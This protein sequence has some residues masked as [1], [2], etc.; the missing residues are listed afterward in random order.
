MVSRAV[1]IENGPPGMVI[2]SGYVSDFEEFDQPGEVRAQITREAF[3]KA[4]A[5]AP[6]VNLLLDNEQVPLARTQT[7]TVEL[8]VDDRGFKIRATVHAAEAS[9]IRGGEL[10]FSFKAKDQQWSDDYTRRTITELDM[11]KADIVIVTG[12]RK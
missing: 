4:V 5:G 2:V 9:R 1:H 10:G 12:G 3:G 8:S 7:G 11:D 6:S